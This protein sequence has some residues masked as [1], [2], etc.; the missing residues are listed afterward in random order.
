MIADPKFDAIPVSSLRTQIQVW[1]GQLSQYLSSPQSTAKLHF[2]FLG[3]NQRSPSQKRDA[4]TSQSLHAQLPDDTAVPQQ[5]SG[6]A[7]PPRRTPLKILRRGDGLR[8]QG[9]DKVAPQ[10]SPP[11]GSNVDD[12]VASPVQ[13]G[14]T[15]ETPSVRHAGG[16]GSVPATTS[17]SRATAKGIAAFLEQVGGVAVTPVAIRPGATQRISRIE[18]SHQVLEQRRQQL[19]STLFQSPDVASPDVSNTTLMMSSVP[20]FDIRQHRDVFCLEHEESTTRSFFL[21]FRGRPRQLQEMIASTLS[22]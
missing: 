9:I 3:S 18:V 4:V 13:Q 20:R 12:H 22:S 6:H 2:L 7:A 17:S 10:R 15:M 19:L 8:R 5:E 1:Q 16:G 11:K 21:Q 14:A